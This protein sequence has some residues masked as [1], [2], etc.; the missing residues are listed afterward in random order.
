VKT[1]AVAG[2]WQAVGRPWHIVFRHDK[3]VGMSSIGSPDSQEMEPGT[4][5]LQPERSVAIKTKTGRSFR[6]EFREVTPDQF[7]LIDLENGAVT[8]FARGR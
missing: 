8:V 3:T 2:E 6:A 1:S 4:Y 5:W 7:D